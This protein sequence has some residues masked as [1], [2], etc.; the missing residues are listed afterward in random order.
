MLPR[1]AFPIAR[2]MFQRLPGL[3]APGMD[4]H[5]RHQHRNRAPT[6]LDV[7][8]SFAGRSL[9]AVQVMVLSLAETHPQDHIRLWLFEQDIPDSEIRAF[10][11]FCASLG[12]VELRPL[13]VPD[14]ASFRQ[15]KELGGKPDSARFL[16]FVA[17]E[18]LPDDLSRVIYLDAADIIVADDLVPL[19][20]HPFLGKYLI[21]CR[22]FNDL[23]PLLIGNARRA[24]R[25]GVPAG[26]I[27]MVSRGLI[28]S[29]AIVVNLDRLRRERIGIGHYLQTAEWASTRLQLRFGDQGLFSL[30]HGSH[31]TRLH[32]RY[33]H[34]F[35]AEPVGRMMRDPAVLHYA[36]R[37]VKPANWQL[38][39]AQEALV[40]DHLHRSG[41]DVLKLNKHLALRAAHLPYLRRWWDTC[42]RTPGHARLAPEAARR[43]TATLARLEL[44]TPER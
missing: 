3:W 15:L 8:T 2:Q 27:R 6:R 18:L 42:A 16:W 44:G 22:E 36:G 39:T 43:M 29:G 9:D 31:Y 4:M 1:N 17:H 7:M 28:N 19:L 14:A 24:Y 20:T 33:N 11:T 13:R 40:L 23:P 30:T 25:C 26:M 12:N 5:L 21:A 38:S 37:I 34:R 32:D 41:S 35:W 10:G